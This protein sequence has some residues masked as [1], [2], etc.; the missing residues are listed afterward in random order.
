MIGARAAGLGQ[1]KLRTALTAVAVLLGVAMIAGTYVQ[2]DQIR[3]AFERASTHDRQPAAWTSMVQPKESFT[4]QL[5]RHAGRCTSA[6]STRVAAVPGVASAEGELCQP[7]RS[8]STAGGRSRFAP[9][10]VVATVGEPFDP[11]RTSR[12]RLPRRSGEV[13]VDRKPAEDRA[14]ESAQRVGLATRS[15]VE[16]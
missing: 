5:R 7:A 15:G 12:G 1:R 3:A 14:C 10:I 6:W 4:S 8:W 9:A 2:T 11:I 16:R 13:R